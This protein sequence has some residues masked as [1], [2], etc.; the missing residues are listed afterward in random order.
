M[1]PLRSLR[2]M[3]DR[4]QRD[5]DRLES[6]HP[7]DNMPENIGDEAE[8]QRNLATAIVYIGGMIVEAKERRRRGR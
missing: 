5:L 7:I 6:E 8:T 1:I 2:A 3:R 4:W